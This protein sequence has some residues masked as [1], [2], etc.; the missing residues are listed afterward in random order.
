M[1]VLLSALWLGILTS[2]SPCP[3]ATNVAAVSFL[4]RKVNHPKAVLWSG[5]A[6]SLGR[7][8]AYV[9]LGAVIV[10]SLTGVPAVANFLQ[11]YMNRILGPVLVVVGLFLLGVLRLNVSGFALS[12]E[13]QNSLAESGVWGSFLLGVVF[14]LSFCPISAALFFGSLIP[15][16]LNNNFGLVFPFVFGVGTGLPVVVFA[17]GVAL[18]VKS[19]TRWFSH[20]ARLEVYMRKVTGAIFIIVGIYYVWA[21]VV[22]SLTL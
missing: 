13:R 7:V 15:L 12:S 20:V 5:L 1:M 18:G 4:S 14:A 10:S 19:M 6:Y 17:V 9:V 8:V 22:P 11:K 16:A 2:I 21:Y 3:L